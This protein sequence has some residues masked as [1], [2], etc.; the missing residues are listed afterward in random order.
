MEEKKEQHKKSIRFFND[1]E[2]RAVWDEE[3]NCWWFSATDI[4][5]AINDEPDY[6]KAGNYWR[7][8]KRKL[9]QEGIEPVS[10]THNFK[11]E[12][13]D[14]KMRI[15][16]VLDS[17]GVT[18]LAKH[19]PNNRAN[20]FLDWFTYSD[21]T[22]D[23]QSR[24]KAYQL[25]ESG[26][27]KVLSQAAYNVYN[28]FMLISLEVCMTLLDKSARRISPKVALPLLIVCTSLLRYKR[29]K[30]CQKTPSTKY[31]TSMSK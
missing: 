25:Y 18:L 28:R 24:K 17:E 15:A 21:N 2:V 22:L 27:L 6:T 16:D 19:Y 30:E 20:E 8:L 14:G 26:L 12:A 31:W 29:L 11:F 5:R 4:V 1:R 3:S 9:K 10:A 7:W 23:G 13:P